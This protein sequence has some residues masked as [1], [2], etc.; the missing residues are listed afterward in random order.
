MVLFV[1]KKKI[2]HLYSNLNCM[3]LSVLCINMSHGFKYIG[4]LGDEHPS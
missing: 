4:K 2:L 1:V 3:N